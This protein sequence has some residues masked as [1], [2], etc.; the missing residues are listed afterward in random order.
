MHMQRTIEYIYE[1]IKTVVRTG[2]GRGAAPQQE[3]RGDHRGDR[4]PRGPCGELRNKN[5]VAEDGI[6]EMVRIGR[7][8]I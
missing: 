7:A 6:W 4:S 5:Q 2:R 8:P 1:I 3:P